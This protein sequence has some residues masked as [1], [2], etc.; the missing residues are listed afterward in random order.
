MTR[1]KRMTR[2]L[3]FLLKWLSLTLTLVC[4]SHTH[5]RQILLHAQRFYRQWKCL[6]VYSTFILVYNY[7]SFFEHYHLWNPACGVLANVYTRMQHWL[8]LS[9]I[10]V[11]VWI[12]SQHALMRCHPLFYVSVHVAQ[13]HRD[14][15]NISSVPVCDLQTLLLQVQLQRCRNMVQ[16][17]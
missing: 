6:T 5:S 10:Y 2:V 16:R 13:T 15:S 12:W 7:Y 11:S 8:N 9:R 3:L 1:G 14:K 17:S 4:L